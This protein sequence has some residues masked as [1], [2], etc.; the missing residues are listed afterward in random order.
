MANAN[1]AKETTAII[2]DANWRGRVRS[3]LLASKNWDRDWGFL[4]ESG[5]AE[6]LE[7][8]SREA[9]ANGSAEALQRTLPVREDALPKGNVRMQLETYMSASQRK[10]Y[11]NSKKPT[12]AYSA[13]V[14]TSQT[15]GWRHTKTLEVFGPNMQCK[16]R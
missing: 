10:A 14:T 11:S 6:S 15:I 1:T 9:I 7:T 16:L 2:E 5:D 4:R 8:Q 13:P 3:E 12:E